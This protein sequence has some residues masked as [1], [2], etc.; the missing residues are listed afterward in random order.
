MNPYH[1]VTLWFALQF[2]V[3]VKGESIQDSVLLIVDG[4]H[5]ALTVDFVDINFLLSFEHRVPPNLR[6]LTEWQL[7]DKHNQVDCWFLSYL[8]GQNQYV[9]VFVL[10]TTQL[11][12]SRLHREF[13]VL[14]LCVNSP[15]IS[16]FSSAPSLTHTLMLLA[17]RLTLTWKQPVE[18]K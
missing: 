6:I 11:P 18:Y 5:G 12:G 9:C 3:V 16:V 17:C 4:C 10:T 15:S 14:I 13:S 7:K 2:L 8:C 1:L